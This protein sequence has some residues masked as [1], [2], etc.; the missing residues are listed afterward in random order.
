MIFQPQ[1]PTSSRFLFSALN[2]E[3]VLFY[4]FDLNGRK[5]FR[6]VDLPK[7]WIQ[8]KY[9]GEDGEQLVLMI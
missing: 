9:S 5:L 4:Q 1:V 8:L 7:T 6:T 2:Q 3:H